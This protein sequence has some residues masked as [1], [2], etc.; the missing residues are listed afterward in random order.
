MERANAQAQRQPARQRRT[1]RADNKPTKR[2]ELERQVLR[3]QEHTPEHD[4]KRPGR[5][6][7]R[8]GHTLLEGHRRRRRSHQ[9]AGRLKRAKVLRRA[10]S[11][12]QAKQQ[13]HNSTLTVLLAVKKPL[14]MSKAGALKFFYGV[15]K[16][17]DAK[18]N[19]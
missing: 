5:L 7:G 13:R 18:K 6:D 8:L 11:H 12:A 10:V 2:L 17:I 15:E 16:I 3:S 9:G 1:H 19:L 14:L 4:N